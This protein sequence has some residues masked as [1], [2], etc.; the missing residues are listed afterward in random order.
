MARGELQ[1]ELEC[2][3]MNENELFARLELE[4]S[5]EKPFIWL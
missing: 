1:I 4:N 2:T 3:I 5:L